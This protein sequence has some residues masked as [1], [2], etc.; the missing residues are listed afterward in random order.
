MAGYDLKWFSRVLQTSDLD[1]TLNVKSGMDAVTKPQM[2]CYN[3]SSTGADNSLAAT[4]AADYFLSAYGYLSIG[5][6]IYVY[7]NNGVQL[8]TVATSSSA[9][10]TTTKISA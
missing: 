7:A 9:A 3:A 8:L 1:K 4:V 5:D 6:T 2:W 10:V